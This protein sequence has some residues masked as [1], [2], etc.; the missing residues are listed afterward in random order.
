MKILV[1]G[2]TGQLG[3]HVVSLLGERGS[4]AYKVLALAKADLDIA[5]EDA[6][7]GVIGRHQPDAILHCAAYTNVEAA[8]DDGKALNW[9]I[10]RDG[11]ANVARAAAAVSAKLVYVSTDYV[12]DGSEDATYEPLDATNPLNEYGAAK[13]AGEHAVLAYCPS[14]HIVRTSWVYAA[15]G[16]NFVNTMLRLSETRDALT[17]VDDQFGRP[18]YAADLAAFMVYLV[19]Q[20]IE[21]GIYHFANDGVTNWFEFAKAVL[22]NKDVTVLPVDSGRFPQ[23]AKRPARS[24]LSL[25]KAKAAGFLV[26]TWEDALERCLNRE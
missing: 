4:E 23:K 20:D 14:A 24:V 18:T 10:N 8:E 26:S 1:T 25:E 21:S 2:A 7:M 9:R 19:E 5:D 22:R 11:S 17:V 15:H 3:R 16:H 6:V 13:L 12:F